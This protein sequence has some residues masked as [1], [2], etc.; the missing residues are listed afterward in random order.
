MSDN[1]NPEDKG[2]AGGK[3]QLLADLAGE[4]ERRKKAE[5]AA[6]TA[7]QALTKA[8]ETFQ[9]EVAG[10]NEKVASAEMR[11]ARFQVLREKNI[12]SELDDFINGATA[13]EIV[14]SADK[15]LE[16]FK[17]VALDGG[18]PQPLGMRPDG[19]QGADETALNSDSLEQ[20]LR[21][22]LNL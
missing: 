9:Q 5:A 22:A 19:T 20:G 1:P 6:A 4:R 11:A 13:E 17:P 7:E 18:A 2:A 14:A 10:L 12:P 8:Q 21:D 15:A 16:A 3:E